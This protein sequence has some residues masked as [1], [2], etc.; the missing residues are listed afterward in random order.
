MF[1]SDLFGQSETDFERSRVTKDVTEAVLE[2][3]DLSEEVLERLVEAQLNTH[4]ISLSC[5]R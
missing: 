2:E 3:L 5:T 1:V 4:A